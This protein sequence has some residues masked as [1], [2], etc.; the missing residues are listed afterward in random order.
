MKI[1]ILLFAAVTATPLLADDAIPKR[2]DFSHY[3][4]MVNRSPFAVATAVVPTGTAD[5]AK[6]LYIANAGK[7]PDG[8]WMVTL[9]SSTDR[10]FKKYLTSHE[11]EDGYFIQDIQWSD[12]V[13]ETKVTISKDGQYATLTFNQALLAQPMPNAP[14]LPQ[15]MQTPAFQPGA[16]GPGVLRPAPIPSLPPQPM[17]TPVPQQNRV[18]TRGVIQRSPQQANATPTPAE[19]NDE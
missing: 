16:L 17:A 6:D 4:A 15:P 5:F 7:L 8:G 2:P 3:Q 12:R 18:F 9:M 19:E 14:A 11:P 13:G 10:N 1:R